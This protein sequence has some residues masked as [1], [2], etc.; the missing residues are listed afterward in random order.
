MI[1]SVT[2]GGEH[3]VFCLSSPLFVVLFFTHMSAG[4]WQPHIIYL[5]YNYFVTVLHMTI[6]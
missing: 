1:L 6:I 4:G 3:E 5:N 2:D